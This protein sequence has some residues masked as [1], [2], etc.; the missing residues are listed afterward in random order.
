MICIYDIF[1]GKLISKIDKERSKYQNAKMQQ[2]QSFNKSQENILSKTFMATKEEI[3]ALKDLQNDI[4]RLQ[5]LINHI[6]T[7]ENNATLFRKILKKT[8]EEALK[9]IKK[10]AFKYIDLI[11]DEIMKNTKVNIDHIQKQINKAKKNKSECE[12]S[13]TYDPDNTDVKQ[14]INVGQKVTE[15][16]K[17]NRDIFNRDQAK[18]IWNSANASLNTI[19]PQIRNDKELFKI[20]DTCWSVFA[21]GF[22][23][24]RTCRELA[25]KLM[26]PDENAD[27][28]KTNNNASEFWFI[29]LPQICDH[30]DTIK[31][32]LKKLNIDIIEDCGFLS[33]ELSK[34][35]IKKSLKDETDE[36]IQFS[37][38]DPAINVNDWWAL[39]QYMDIEFNYDLIQQNMLTAMSG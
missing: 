8:I 26:Y 39:E 19:L 2:T 32:E 11:Y 34:K 31:K 20:I 4:K 24:Y 22:S 23:Y 5:S 37:D 35:I 27:D 28:Q 21:C 3:K 17:E 30:M 38:K 36:P 25:L 33:N 14:S 18:L 7:G 16:I 12:Q 15:I 1:T 6:K 9:D 13:L 10:L 29:L